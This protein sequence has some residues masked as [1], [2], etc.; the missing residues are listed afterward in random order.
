MVRFH[1]P[2]CNEPDAVAI[3][4]AGDTFPI[5]EIHLGKWVQGV[6][7]RCESCWESVRVYVTVPGVEHPAIEALSTAPPPLGDSSISDTD[8][9]EIYAAWY[10]EHVGAE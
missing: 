1:C 8:W 7:V 3:P 6:S 9:D 10:D 5:E 4:A 2:H